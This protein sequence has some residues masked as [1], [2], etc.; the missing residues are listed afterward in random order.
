MLP[1]AV[2]GGPWFDGIPVLEQVEDAYNAASS[3]L[4]DNIV[5]QVPGSG[6]VKDA[7]AKGGDWIV[8]FAKTPVGRFTITVVSNNLYQPLAHIV[9]PQAASAVWATPGMIAG[10]SFSEAY[11]EDLR[12]RLEGLVAFVKFGPPGAIGAYY[13]L[14][15]ALV[16]SLGDPTKAAEYAAGAFTEDYT[17]LVADPEFRSFLEAEVARIAG[18]SPEQARLYLLE[19]LSPDA[20]AKRLR[21][22]FPRIR[23]DQIALAVNAFYRKIVFDV[24]KEFDLPSGR[25]RSIN[26][27]VIPSADPGRYFESTLPSTV[28]YGGLNPVPPAARPKVPVGTGTGG[29][30]V[31]VATE[32]RSF[33]QLLG[34]LAVVSAP[35]WV[36]W[37]LGRVR[38]LR[39]KSRRS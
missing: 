22:R 30:G 14:D 13:G 1:Y 33:L 31:R 28:E 10:E 4:D 39:N 34:V 24:E 7:L 5:K 32:E 11:I 9:G 20:L 36:P 37:G 16:A 21:T 18:M 27:F 25:R 15:P 3:W 12:K 17:K 35:V 6:W 8:A 26:P 19:N 38:S 29:M 2:V 23:E